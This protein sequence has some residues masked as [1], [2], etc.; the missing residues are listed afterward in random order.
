[1]AA[2]VRDV[3][4]QAAAVVTLRTRRV[5]LLLALLYVATLVATMRLTGAPT[6]PLYDGLQT[7][8][9]YNYVV[10]PPAL[11]ATN[12][13]PATGRAT[14]PLL[15]TGTDFASVST[16]EASPQA[17]LTLNEKAIAPAPPAK[18]AVITLT[19]RDPASFAALPDGNVPDGNAYVI[20]VQL[21]PGGK[22]VP[23]FTTPATISLRRPGAGIAMFFSVDG[24]SWT[25]PESSG[26]ADVV[27][28]LVPGPGIVVIGGV[29]PPSHS[30]TPAAGGSGSSG[31]PWG[32]AGAI[33]AGIA[34][35]GG[36]AYALTR[37]RR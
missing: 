21:Q 31:S 7:P 29:A 11:A 2:D 37:G 28:A 1:V 15:A 8:V 34:V 14:I 13:R 33:A 5:G 36:L 30:A 4:H 25:K 23:S 35:I 27:A 12:T 10:P 18:S 22:E 9:P 6:L 20:K 19:P 24:R 3:E 17:T 16:P 32:I 26:S